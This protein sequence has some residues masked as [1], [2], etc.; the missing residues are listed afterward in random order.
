MA[1]TTRE[2]ATDFIINI[3]DDDNVATTLTHADEHPT[4][5]I[6]ADVSPPQEQFP[7]TAPHQTNVPAVVFVENMATPT[8][9]PTSDFINIPDDDNVPATPTHADEHP[10]IGIAAD[11]N[12]PQ[13]Q[14][15]IIAPH[16]TN[17]PAIESVENMANTTREPTVDFIINIPDD[18]NV[19][20]TPTHADEHPT[21]GITA[22]V[23]PPQ[24]QFP[25]TAPHQTNVPA[26]VSVEN[27][28]TP[29]R[30]PVADFINIPD[31]D[32]VPATPTHADEHP[33][34]GIAADVNP[35]QEQFPIR[36]P[37]QT[38][39]PAIES[40]ENMA[41]TTREP[42]ADFIINIPDDDNVATTPTHAD[43]HPTIG[44]ATDVS[45][46]QEQFPITAP[47]QTNVPT[48]ESVENM[49]TPTREPAADFIINI[50]DDNNVPATPTHVDEH[51]TIGIVEQ[52]P[53][54]DHDVPA[55]GVEPGYIGSLCEFIK[56]LWHLHIGI[57]LDHTIAVLVANEG[58]SSVII[59]VSCSLHEVDC[60]TS[61]DTVRT[62]IRKLTSLVAFR[63][64][65]HKEDHQLGIILVVPPGDNTKRK[66]NCITLLDCNH[67]LLRF[68]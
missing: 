20:S 32:N 49:A 14:F 55:A 18:D 12:P 57:E 61:E 44:I 22:D 3:P 7:I 58:L 41:I 56:S 11:V 66:S 27:M 60:E 5:G 6:V 15:P 17:V 23:S 33:T 25:I 16:Q 43:E 64:I 26:I 1:T 54:V 30:E 48:V 35:P 24:E 10:T 51:P 53:D 34:I 46:P 63:G 59:H 31:D 45:P 47:H 28:A 39:V 2:P 50:P 19:A 36:A 62:E 9:E 13:E 8:R 37:H 52:F 29:T 40:V 21:I 67:I 65:S 68:R 4:I 42:A 38:N